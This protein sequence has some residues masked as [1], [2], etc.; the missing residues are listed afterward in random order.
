MSAYNALGQADPNA[1]I[2]SKA[3]TVWDSAA[4]MA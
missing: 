2:H 3:S 4:A 1:M